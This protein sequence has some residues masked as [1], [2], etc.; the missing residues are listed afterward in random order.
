MLFKE[1][2]LN[3]NEENII[4]EKNIWASLDLGI[5]VKFVINRIF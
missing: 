5:I 3:E 2:K 1:G 4:A